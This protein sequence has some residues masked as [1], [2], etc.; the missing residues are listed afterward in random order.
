MM[1]EHHKKSL[2]LLDE[3]LNH[4]DDE[5]FLADYRELEKNVGP[6]VSSFIEGFSIINPHYQRSFNIEN[7]PNAGNDKEFISILP[8]NAT[9][10]E[11]SSFDDSSV[12][13]LAA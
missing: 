10:D 3:W 2:E 5:T 6:T 11:T 8:I 12:Y 13:S 9:L 7:I 4:V 1:K